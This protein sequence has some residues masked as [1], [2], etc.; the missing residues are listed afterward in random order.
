M[1]A[2]VHFEVPVE[3]M[4]RAKKFWTE[5]M[6]WSIEGSKEF[7]DYVTIRTKTVDGNEGIGG[8]MM[9]RQHPNQQ[10]MNYF[11]VDSVDAYVEKVKG[12]GGR[13]VME[14]SPVPGMGWFSVCLDTENNVFGVWQSDKSAK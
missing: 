6:G 12:L 13:V 11:D 8:G 1:P 10:I 7:P 5:L 14:K 9:K 2:I 4:E 3:D